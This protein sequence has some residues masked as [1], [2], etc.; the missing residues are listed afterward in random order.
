MAT[1]T[2]QGRRPCGEKRYHMNEYCYG[3]YSHD[4]GVCK[5][6][7]K[8]MKAMEELDCGPCPCWDCLIK[9]TCMNSCPSHCKL[10]KQVMEYIEV[11]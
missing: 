7:G 3:C 10:F 4:R 1:N 6:Q 5:I 2:D 8:I 9:M 11:R